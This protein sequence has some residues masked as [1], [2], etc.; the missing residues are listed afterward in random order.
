M[1]FAYETKMKK[2][3]DDL[4]VGSINSTLNVKPRL[5]YRGKAFRVPKKR[6]DL[7]E[8]RSAFF[9]TFGMTLICDKISEL[10]T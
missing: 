7:I 6:S 8:I 10:Q 4:L 2:R 5:S 1:T 9:N 3:L